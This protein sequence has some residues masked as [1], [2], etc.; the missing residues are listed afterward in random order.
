MNAEIKTQTAYLSAPGTVSKLNEYDETKRKVQILNEY[1][2][3]VVNINRQMD[4]QDLIGT[5]LLSDIAKSM[6][7]G[8]F[9]KSLSISSDGIQLQ[10]VSNSRTAIAE[11]EHNFIKLGTFSSVYVS[12][13][14]QDTSSLNNVDAAGQTGAGAGAGTVKSGSNNYT[15]AL[16][17]KLGDVKK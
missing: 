17:C 16:T 12:S 6:P 14:A 10:G 7:E 11:L 15:F 3:I 1:N 13:I 5:T 4:D 9:F 2:T 8:T